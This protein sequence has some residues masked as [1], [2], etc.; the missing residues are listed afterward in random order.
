MH[1]ACGPTLH[2]I[3]NQTVAPHGDGLAAR[4]YVDAVVLGPDGVTGAHAV[5]W[6]DDELRYGDDGWRIARRTFTSVLIEPVGG[7]GSAVLEDV[8]A[9]KR[10]KARY[11]R[12]IDTKDWDGLRQVFSDDV[13]VD[14]TASGGNVVTGATPF[15][16]FLREAIGDVITVHH[17]HTPEIEVTSPTTATGVWAMEDQLRW[18]DGQEL[19]GYGHYHETYEK[20]D[21]AWR[22]STSTL[23]R[24]RMDLTAGP[25]S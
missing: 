22:I 20:V 4:S 7:S 23:T 15:V 1:A 3:T 25:G 10:L 17:G 5:G 21:G 9:I 16:A 24:L 14:T 12:L 2:R 8:E 19:R 6:Y 11:F 13:V 18:P